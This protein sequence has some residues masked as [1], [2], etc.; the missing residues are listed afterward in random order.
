MRHTVLALLAATVTMF[1]T[2]MFASSQLL[3]LLGQVTWGRY[4]C[5]ISPLLKNSSLFTVSDVWLAIIVIGIILW[6]VVLYLEF[7]RPS[8]E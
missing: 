1:G 7:M 3:T 4:T 5:E 6:C 2:V 8:E